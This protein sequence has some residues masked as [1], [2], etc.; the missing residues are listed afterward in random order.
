MLGENI[1]EEKG[2]ITNKRVLETTPLPKMETT[3]EAKGKLL[4]IEHQTVGTF[5]SVL[6]PN[7]L[8]YGDGNGIV[9]TKEG[10]V[11]WKGNGVGRPNERGGISFRGAIY[12][13]TFVERLR[14]LNGVAMVYE[15]DADENDN[16]SSKGFEWK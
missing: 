16:V 1:L 5:W 3:F 14:K 13:Q 12:C 10:P 11:T 8:F 15:Y 4:G 2:K 9:L 6:Q 7:G